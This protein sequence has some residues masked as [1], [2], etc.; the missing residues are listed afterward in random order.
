MR[1]ALLVLGIILLASCDAPEHKQLISNEATMKIV[2]VEELNITCVGNG[3]DGYDCLPNWF[4]NYNPNAAC[5]T[6][7]E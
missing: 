6:E 7:I 1:E 5:Q 3:F 2:P 4:I